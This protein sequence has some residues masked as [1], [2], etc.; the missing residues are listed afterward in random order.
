MKKLIFFML[1]AFCIPLIPQVE[2]H[3]QTDQDRI[4][5]SDLH[6]VNTFQ[7]QVKFE[8]KSTAPKATDRKMNDRSVNA[9]LEGK[10]QDVR[11]KSHI[12]CQVRQDELMSLQRYTGCVG[13]C[14]CLR[15]ELVGTLKSSTRPGVRHGTCRTG[16][17]RATTRWTSRRFSFKFPSQPSIVPEDM[18]MIFNRSSAQ[19]SPLTRITG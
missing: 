16:T 6:K 18:G 2:A 17:D 13:N 3:I 15:C 10:A 19:F 7:I 1:L 4:Q 12:H 9:V 11:L 14:M 5:K 8:T